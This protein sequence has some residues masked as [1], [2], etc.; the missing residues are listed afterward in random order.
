MK[1]RRYAHPELAAVMLFCH[2][3]GH[4]LTAGL[5]VGHYVGHDLANAF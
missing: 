3:L 2:R 4:G 5:H 1:L